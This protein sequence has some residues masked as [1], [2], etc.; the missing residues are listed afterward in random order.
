MG[1]GSA[2]DDDAEV[3]GFGES[4]RRESVQRRRRRSSIF[5]RCCVKS[6]RLRRDSD[7]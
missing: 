2:S 6:E 4:R 3:M 7:E 5:F 1:D